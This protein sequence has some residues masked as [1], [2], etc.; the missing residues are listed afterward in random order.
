MNW[1]THYMAWIMRVSGALTCTML[2]AA[3]APQAALQA[4]FGDTLSGPVAE[5]VVRNWGVLIFLMGVLLIIG[6]SKL[7]V[8]AT[9]LCVAGASKVCFI[10]LV[11]AQGTAFLSHSAG[12]AVLLDSGFVLVYAAY[13][14]GPQRH[15]R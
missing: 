9:A 2:Y 14:L 8:R 13:L 15:L 6:A 7:A 3:I 1:I 11:L 5:L 12:L 10:S 4:H